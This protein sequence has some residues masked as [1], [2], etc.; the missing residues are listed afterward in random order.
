MS[1]KF[2]I[3]KNQTD[4]DHQEWIQACESGKYN[5][6]CKVIDISKNDWLENIINEDFDCHL[7]RPPGEI[8]HFKQ[9]YD[10]RLYI[11]HNILKQKI[12]PT[13]EEIL[14][15]ENKKFLSYWLK[16]NKIPHPETWIFYHKDEALKFIKDCTLPIVAKTSIGASGSGVNIIKDRKSLEKYINKVFSYKGIFRKVGPNLRRGDLGRRLIKR[17]KNA[18]HSYK[19]FRKKYILKNITAQKWFVILQKYIQC[20]FEWRAVRIGDSYFAHKKLRRFGELFSGTSR[21]GWD[22]PPEKLL[23]FAKFVCDKRNFFSQAVD[24]FEDE[25]GQYLVNEL[26]CFFGS[27]NPHQMI[28]DGKPGRYIYRDSQ[29]I[30]EEGIFNTNNSFDLRVEHVIK[31]LKNKEL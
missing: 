21:V 15:H 23:D 26:Q 11:I 19:Y 9:L 14:I 28:L 12:Y 8:S 30:F 20:D 10:E 3:L 7:T 24:V 31:L 27:K 6:K 22:R 4:E 25:N 18:P 5:I 13:Y 16:A 1:Y 2:S 17:L 29:W